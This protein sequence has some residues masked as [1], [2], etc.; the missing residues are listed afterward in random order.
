MLRNVCSVNLNSAAFHKAHSPA[1]EVALC[2][3]FLSTVGSVRAAAFVSSSASMSVNLWNAH[4][5]QSK[6]AAGFSLSFFVFSFS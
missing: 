4:L 6:F 2:V 3:F 1:S 5:A